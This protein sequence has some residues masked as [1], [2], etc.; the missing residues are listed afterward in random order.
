MIENF[1]KFLAATFL[2]LMVLAA[3]G[4]ASAQRAYIA[5]QTDNTVSVIDVATDTVIAT[6]AVGQAPEGVAVSPDG[7]RVYVSNSGS[8]T[9][10]VIDAASKVVTATVSVEANPRAMSI[11]PNAT[12]L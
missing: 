8:N 5:N 9:V 3:A 11:A 7:A 10:S 12:R 4:S 1:S 2:G 6:I